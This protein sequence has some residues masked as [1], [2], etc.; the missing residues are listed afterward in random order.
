MLNAPYAYIHGI[1]VI[2]SLLLLVS[3]V[4]TII[5]QFRGEEIE[6]TGSA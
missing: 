2:G 5:L 4:C 3:F 6:P 1:M